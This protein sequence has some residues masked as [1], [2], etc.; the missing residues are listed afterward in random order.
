MARRRR[1]PP[2]IKRDN[3]PK[4]TEGGSPEAEGEAATGLPAVVQQEIDQELSQP[5]PDARV[6]VRR[7]VVRVAHDV[8][9]FSGPLPPPSYLRDYETVIPARVVGSSP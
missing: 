4:A 2:A 5:E 6:R 7:L 8:A 9:E 1:T 3:I